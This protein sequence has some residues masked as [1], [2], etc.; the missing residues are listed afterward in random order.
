MTKRIRMEDRIGERH[1]R[2]II[3]GLAYR[4]NSKA[5][6]MAECDCGKSSISPLPSVLSG[7][8][9]SCGCLAKEKSKVNAL[10]MSDAKRGKPGHR[11]KD[12]KH[13]MIT[14]LISASRNAAK[15]HKPFP[16]E[17]SL[18][19]EEYVKLINGKC[20]YCGEERVDTKKFENK[21]ARQGLAPHFGKYLK[22]V[23]IDRVDS[24]KGYVSN[25]VVPCCAKCNRM[26]MDLAQKDFID[27]CKKISGRFQ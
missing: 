22:C 17:F 19:R 15:S 18:T 21:R 7:Y 3:T 1:N 4:N 23:G 11:L 13:T 16:V 25:N 24:S 9:K 6:V 20:Y 2:L 5:Y 27:R 12:F 14:T 10:K 8:T 26:K